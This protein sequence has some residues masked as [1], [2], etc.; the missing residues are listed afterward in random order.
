MV[1]CR[2][3][4]VTGQISPVECHVLV[5]KV[6]LLLLKLSKA[7][8]RLKPPPCGRNPSS[9]FLRSA[10]GLFPAIPPL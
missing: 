2:A 7:L 9:E 8:A 3:R 1:V 6:S 4:A 10:R 5:P